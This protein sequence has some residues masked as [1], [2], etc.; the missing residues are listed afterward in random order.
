MQTENRVIK[1]AKEFC[2][3]LMSHINKRFPDDEV[4][5]S[6]RMFDLEAIIKLDEKELLNFGN[7][8]LFILEE[9]FGESRRNAFGKNCR[10]PF[11]FEKIKEEYTHFKFM[12]VENFQP[13]EDGKCRDVMQAWQ[14]IFQF[15]SRE[16]EETLNLAKMFLIMPTNTAECERG[17][18][19]RNLLKTKLRN[20]LKTQTIDYLMR[21]GLTKDIN[22]YSVLQIFVH[23]KQGI[24]FKF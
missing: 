15:H 4:L 19:R 8:Q 22:W 16:F 11:N 1:F 24:I 12:I 5:Q 17:F 10:L 23:K 3:K 7:S 9:A 14:D 21:V 2:R 18:S 13:G 20:R 6:F